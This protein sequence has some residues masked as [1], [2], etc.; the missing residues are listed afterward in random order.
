[1]AVIRCTITDADIAWKRELLVGG[2][3]LARRATRDGCV[4]L[5]DNVTV[6]SGRFPPRGGSVRQPRLADHGDLGELV[7]QV[8]G[9]HASTAQKMVAEHPGMVVILDEAEARHAELTIERRQLV[10]RLAA[11]DAELTV[12]ARRRAQADG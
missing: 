8:R 12:V 11:V 1:M 4:R 3:A 6:V 7:L 9:L 2:R 5:A 10:A